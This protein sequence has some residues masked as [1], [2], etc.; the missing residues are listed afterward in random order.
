MFKKLVLSSATLAGALAIVALPA[1]AQRISRNPTP[2]ATLS[3]SPYAGYIAFGDL[4]NGPLNTSVKNASAPVYGAQVNLPLGSSLSI[5]GNVAYTQPDLSIGVPILGS[6]SFGKSNIWLYDAGLQLSAPGYGNGARGFF[7]FVQ[8]G[9]GAMRYDVQVSGLSRNAT[10]AAFTAGIGADI[11]LM[12]NVG[13]RLMA[14]DYVGKFDF[15]D[16]TTLNVNT[17]TSNNVSLSAGLKL[18]F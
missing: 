6:V 8:V 1:A 7:P 12:Q 14:R 2:A 9:G 10:N 13:I 4:V 15:N 11:P 5:V 16:A 18:S 17:K 3:I